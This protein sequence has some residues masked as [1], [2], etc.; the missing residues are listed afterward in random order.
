MGESQENLQIEEREL[1]RIASE[2]VHESGSQVAAENRSEIV[3]GNP[4]NDQVQPNLLQQQ[5]WKRI[6]QYRAPQ[7]LVVPQFRLLQLFI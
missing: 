4:L 1:A 2:L 6:L 7:R 5:V 3:V